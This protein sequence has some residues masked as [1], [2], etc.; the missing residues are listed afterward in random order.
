MKKIVSAVALAA[1]AASLATAE[2]KTSL[3][4]RTG[5][6][7]LTHTFGDNTTVLNAETANRTTSDS[8]S[9]KDSGEYG[10]MEL[11]LTATGKAAENKIEL[12]KYNGWVNFGDFMFKSGKW[13]ARAV[14]RVTNDIGNHEGK[15]WGELTKPGL[16]DKLGTQGKGSDI[17][18]QSN[19]KLT[20]MLAY[21]NKDLGLEARVAFQETDTANGYGKSA[22]DDWVFANDLW[23]VEVGYTLDGLGRILVDAK[24]SYKDQAFALF[25]EPKLAGLEQLTSLVGFT[26]EQDSSAKKA[27]GDAQRE[28]ALGFDARA[29]YAINEQLSVTGMFNW[30]A[31]DVAAS[32]TDVKVASYATWGMVNAT[33]ALNDTFK[34]F[35]SVIYSSGAEA[36]KT[37]ALAK[38]AA[39][40]ASLRIYPGVEIYNTKNAN[41]ITGVAFDINDFSNGDD[42]KNNEN[43]KVT[44]PVLFR[45]RF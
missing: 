31:G 36:G 4:Y 10:G 21:N 45:V 35:C 19:K 26:Y 30:T 15:F 13:D 41:I 40:K 14:G 1:V 3:N 37:A 5:I 20:N 33:Y 25:V 43:M 34:P 18:Q 2:I 12:A 6:D 38:T 17:S 8:L 42:Y 24:T 28:V 27:N 9:F 7:V 23:F 29:R 44:I 11:E 22:S 32:G 16:A 39:Y